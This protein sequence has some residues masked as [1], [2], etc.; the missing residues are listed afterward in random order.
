MTDAFH[1]REQSLENRFFYQQDQKLIEQL[2]A[3]EQEEE[4]IQ[5]LATATGI[6]NHDVLKELLE[7]GIRPDSIVALS[8]VPLIFVAH[9]DKNLDDKEQDAILDAAID[10]GLEP[11]SPSHELLTSWLLKKPE[12]DLLEAWRHYINQLCRELPKERIVDLQQHLLDRCRGIAE[13]T[14]GFLGRGGISESERK[15]LNHIESAF[16]TIHD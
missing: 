12:D 16:V 2:R 8:L 11:D 4:G 9:A 13:A 10:A 3:H 6:H 15:M 14:G 7:N 1:H 5:K